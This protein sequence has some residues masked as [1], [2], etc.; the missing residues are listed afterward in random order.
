MAKRSLL[1]EAKSIEKP[2]TKK[3]YT[4][5]EEELCM[6]WLAGEVTLQQVQG[7]MKFKHSA[8][9]YVFLARCARQCFMKAR[10]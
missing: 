5:E 3:P 7:V 2:V 4:L 8:N 9:T 1:D 10:K 6:A